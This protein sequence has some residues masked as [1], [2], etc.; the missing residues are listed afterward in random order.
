MATYTG[1]SSAITLY[2]GD[3]LTGSTIADTD[4][5]GQDAYT[6][7][8]YVSNGGVTE[9]TCV[10]SGG[11]MYLYEGGSANNVSAVGPFNN[12]NGGNI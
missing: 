8:L 4:Y 1:G 11:K 10:S 6:K 2:E 12:E 7:L 9:D 3:Q 5:T